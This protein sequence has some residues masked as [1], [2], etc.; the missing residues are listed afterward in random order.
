[1][2]RTNPS[3][4]QARMNFT[5]YLGQAKIKHNMAPDVPVEYA[6]IGSPCNNSNTEKNSAKQRAIV[7]MPRSPVRDTAYFGTNTIQYMTIINYIVCP[8]RREDEGRLQ[9]YT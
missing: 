9:T 2:T 7:L 4:S 1:M 6:E 5:P 8:N 3:I